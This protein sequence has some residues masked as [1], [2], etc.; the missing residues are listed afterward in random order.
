MKQRKTVLLADANEEFRLLLQA[1]IEKTG[2]FSVELAGNGCEALQKARGGTADLLLMDT[3][4]PEI[5]GLTVLRV[6]QQL[7]CAPPTMFLS[8]FVSDQILSEAAV[9]G[10]VCFLPKPCEVSFLLG[11]LRGFF[12]TARH[13]EPSAWKAAVSMMLHEIGIPAHLKGYQYLRS[14]IL[15]A[16]MDPESLQGVT[17]I[18]YPAVAKQHRTSAACVERAMRHA[19]D[20]G[21]ERGDPA[22]LLDYFGGTISAARGR[23][24]NSELIALLSDRLRLRFETETANSV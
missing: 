13:P 19:V 7:N 11:K 15:V 6:L 9:L 8:S 23:P 10:A 17:K 16:A 12:M 18:I 5:D 2:E 21:W 4:L 20:M 1:E 24:T 22:V 3:A 14:A